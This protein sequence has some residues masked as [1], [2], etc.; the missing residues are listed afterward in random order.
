[1]REARTSW[2]DDRREGA[3][4]PNSR[5]Q[6]HRRGGPGF[7]HFGDGDVF[8]DGLP[9][10]RHRRHGRPLGQGDLRYLILHLLAEQPRHGYDLI[11]AVEE[12]SGGLYAPSP[13]VV[14]PTLT[15]L[16]ELGFIYMA[17]P[18]TPKK[19][20]SL[21]PEGQEALRPHEQDVQHMLARLTRLGQT[22]GD[23][24]DPEVIRASQNVSRALFLRPGRKTWTTEQATRVA[25]ILDRAAAEIEQI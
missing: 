18:E 22:P 4:R 20:Y 23:S 6:R 5:R 16:E 24:A 8:E 19:L 1:M 9:G 12:L 10:R 14:Y 7:G 3:P 25:E 15:L 21:T 2:T 13:G 11:K 17:E